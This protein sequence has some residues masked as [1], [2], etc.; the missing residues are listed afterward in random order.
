MSGSTGSYDTDAMQACA[1]ELDAATSSLSA[2]TRQLGALPHGALPGPVADAVGRLNRKGHDMV[3]DI[4]DES[5]TLAGGLRK[6]AQSY[7]DLDA[8][9]IRAFGGAR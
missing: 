2:L 4:R 6:A 3:S 5:T 7:A 1:R 9:L 8:S